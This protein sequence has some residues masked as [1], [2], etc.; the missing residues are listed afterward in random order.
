M[1]HK[2]ALAP[3]A[4]VTSGSFA[5]DGAGRL[6]YLSLAA[7]ALVA[8]G[9]AIMRIIPRLGGHRRMP[10]RSSS[11]HRFGGSAGTSS[12]PAWRAPASSG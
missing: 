3:A 7:F 6:F 9:S 5:L 11:L 4:F 2:M 8:M 12:A 10:G 1:Y